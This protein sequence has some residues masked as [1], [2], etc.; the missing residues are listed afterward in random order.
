MLETAEL[1]KAVRIIPARYPMGLSAWAKGRRA[2]TPGPGRYDVKGPFGEGPKYTLKGRIAERTPEPEPPIRTMESTLS[3]KGSSFGYTAYKA[4][5][6]ITPGPNLDREEFGKDGVKYS[7]RFKH[8]EPRVDTPGPAEYTINRDILTQSVSIGTGTRW[9]PIDKNIIVAPDEYSPKRKCPE[10]RPLTIG[11]YIPRPQPKRYGPGPGKYDMSYVMGTDTPKYSVRKG[12]RG[13]KE[14]KNPGP[15]DYQR[16]RE[17]RNETAVPI[18]L[19]SRTPLPHGDICDYPYHNIG[20][21]IKPKKISHG[22]RP[23]TSYETISPGPIYDKPPAIEY[24]PITIKNNYPIPN[25]TAGNPGPGAYFKMPKTPQP[26]SH[27]FAGPTSRGPIDEAKA[28]EEP[29][30]ADY[31]PNRAFDKFERGYYFTS[32]M[33]EDYVPDTAAPYHDTKS[34]LGGP[35]FTIGQKEYF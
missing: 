34:T 31:V 20:G 4:K 12:P 26:E 13:E 21:T 3:R 10:E 29:G 24:K 8:V 6:F 19:K 18:A 25:P 28:A 32:R 33:M 16:I 11:N 30:P 22:T 35:K 23:A 14:S 17:L 1:S 5:E 9:D 15:A 27:G 2:P 7:F